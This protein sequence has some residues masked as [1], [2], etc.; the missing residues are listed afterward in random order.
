MIKD[1]SDEDIVR[2]IAAIRCSA[3]EQFSIALV[4]NRRSD[5]EQYL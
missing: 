1:E 2:E 4:N 5:H 3:R